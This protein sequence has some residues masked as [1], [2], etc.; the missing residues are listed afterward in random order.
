MHALEFACEKWVL[1]PHS[2]LK[3][4]AGKKAEKII[5]AGYRN[6][7]YVTGCPKESVNK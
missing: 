6:E 7:Q 2:V 5:N 4:L 1:K 3:K